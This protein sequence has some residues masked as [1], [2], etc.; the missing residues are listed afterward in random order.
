VP[1]TPADRGRLAPASAAP[2]DGER[3]DVLHRG[4][5]TV[6]EHIVSSAM[7][8]PVT[9][10]QDHDEWVA[11]LEGSATLDVEG[12][13]VV[14]TAGDWIVLPAHRRHRVVATAAGTRWLA[15]HLPSDPPERP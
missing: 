8:D 3:L 7:V 12:E 13:P 9:Y 11:V 6:I 15:V 5:G 1:A 14:L 2:V 10:D 4:G